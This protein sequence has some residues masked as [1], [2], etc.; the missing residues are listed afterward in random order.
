M[1]LPRRGVDLDREIGSPLMG[2]LLLAVCLVAVS[3][4]SAAAKDSFDQFVADLAAKPDAAKAYLDG[5]KTLVSPSG[6]VRSPCALALA[7]LVGSQ[8]GVTLVVKQNKVA[9][10]QKSQLI[11]RD[12]VVEVRA[13][14][15]VVGRFRVLEVGWTGAN[16]DQPLALAAHWARLVSDKDA[17]AAAKAGKLPAPPAITHQIVPSGNPKSDDYDQDERD[18]KEA[19]ETVQSQLSREGDLKDVIASWAEDGAIIYGSA[20]KQR[21]AGKSGRATIGKWKLALESSKKV[22]V[23]GDG[24]VLWGVTT[25]T[26][27]P[28]S[29]GTPITYV[30]FAAFVSRLTSGGGSFVTDPAIVSFAV[31]Q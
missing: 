10:F 7:D 2:K 5:C 22:Y 24:W 28:K 23:D 8:T 13:G 27:R 30:V 31:A 15:K 18:R 29:G 4:T 12:A 14:T 26:A 3:A 16:P 19:T 25:M 17:A 6:Q 21:Y 20:P 11:Y 1:D 9:S